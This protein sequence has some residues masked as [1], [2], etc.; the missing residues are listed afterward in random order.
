MRTNFLQMNID[1]VKKY[2]GMIVAA[3][4]TAATISACDKTSGETSV[5]TLVGD[6]VFRVGQEQTDIVI[7]Y[8]VTGSGSV[9]DVSAAANVDWLA[10]VVEEEAESKADRIVPEG[11]VTLRASANETAESRS[12]VVSLGMAGAKSVRVTVIQSAGTDYV[13]PSGMTFE[14][15]V[16]D[17]TESSVSYTV[18]PNF[19]DRYYSFSFFHAD[20][21]AASDAENR[22]YVE[23]T[24]ADMQEYVRKY[25]ESHEIPYNL[26]SV[27]YK[28]YL[29]TAYNGLD[30]DTDYCLVAFDLSLALSSSGNAKVCRFRTAQVPPSSDVFRVTYDEATC[31]VTFDASGKASG[32]FG[33][34]LTNI[35]IWEKAKAPRELVRSFV[36]T[37]TFS[38]F[39]V[40]EA[41][42]AKS[43][44]IYQ[45]TGLDLDEDIVA[46]VFSYNPSTKKA[47]DIAWLQF[48]YKKK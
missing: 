12:A 20:E 25:N 44:P 45:Y 5:I 3:A 36:E 46:F 17:V 27:L 1:T 11:A 6:S 48:T 35:S 18:A 43:A 40:S 31:Q 47:S 28:G 32:K 42:V 24:V 7:R 15:S 22:S 26:K 8:S 2:F 4:L 9:S 16:A 30:P 37:S 34:G 38:S 13:T 23:K 41:P 21:W 19:Q 39:D 14:L 10:P 29:S 33:Y